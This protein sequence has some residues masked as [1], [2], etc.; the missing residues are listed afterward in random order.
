MNSLSKRNVWIFGAT[1]YIGSALLHHLSKDKTNRI[2]LLVHKRIPFRFLESFNTITGS[3]SAFDP[4]WFER[5]PPDVIFHLARPAGSSTIARSIRSSQ[6]EKA[7]Q[8]LVEIVS[9]RNDSPIVVYVSGSLM[10]GRRSIDDPA[11]EKSP[12]QPDSFG[13]HYIKNENPWLEAQKQGHIDVRFARPGWITGPGS[14]FAHFFWKP[15]QET[16]RV[17]CYGDGSHPMSV[18]HVEDGAAMTDALSRF[19][20]KGQ[21]LNLFAGDIITHRQF[22]DT[23]AGILGTT[24]MDVPYSVMKKRFG[25]A[26]ANALVSSTPLKTLYPDIHKKAK[27]N[28]PKV[29]NVLRHVTGLL[30]NV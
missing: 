8:R 27:I 20:E 15:F 29:E 30:K 12:L 26:T 9:G 3:L 16:G 1:G 11:D 22:C 28:Y 24:T 10:Y 13:R 17:P 21:N 14:W 2:H 7:N 4:L 6:G 18:I 5:Y 23:L 19:G 25:E